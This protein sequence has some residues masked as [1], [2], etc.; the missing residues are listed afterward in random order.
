HV[1]ARGGAER[2]AALR[3]LRVVGKMR[4]GG[5]DAISEI[6]FAEVKARPGLLRREVTRQGLTSVAAWDGKEGWTFDPFRGRR[7]AGR[8][9]ADRDRAFAQEADLDGV[10]VDGKAKGHTVEYLGTEDVDGTQ[11]HKLRVALQDGDTEYVYL[12]PDAF[13]VIRTLLVAHVRGT[14]SEI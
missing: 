8:A 1:A 6:D 14:V 10:L 12:D 11:A 9:S 13:L 4:R 5:G 2:L 3:S 7:A